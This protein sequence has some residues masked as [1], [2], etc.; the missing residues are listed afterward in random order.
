[1]FV[2]GRERPKELSGN[3]TGFVS[4]GGCGLVAGLGADGIGH[5][6][7]FDS[8]DAA[9]APTGGGRFLRQTELEAGDRAGALEI[10]LKKLLEGLLVPG[11]QDDAFGQEATVAGVWRRAALA[12]DTG[13]YMGKNLFFHFEV[14][15]PPPIFR[16]AWVYKIKWY[17]SN[18]LLE[19]KEK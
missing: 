7:V 3:G 11:R 6:G 10:L 16:I 15:I 14:R 17:E 1:L 13:D 9:H 19:I 8:A 18:V 5:A 2:R 12:R 4:H